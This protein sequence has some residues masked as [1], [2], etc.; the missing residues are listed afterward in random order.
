MRCLNCGKIVTGRSQYCSDKCKMAWNRNRK[1]NTEAVI[2][3]AN[4]NK[5]V[6][7]VTAPGQLLS[8]IS[9]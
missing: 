3:N 6:T 7:D 9:E 8:R 2:K 5:S 1:R 4:R